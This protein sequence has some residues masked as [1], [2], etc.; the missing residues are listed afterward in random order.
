MARPTLLPD[1]LFFRIGEVSELV[2]VRP[3]VLR[4]WEEEFGILKPMKTR[5]AHRQYRRRD[6]ELA[7]VIKKL[8]HE[9]GFTV[10][11]AR[12]K[13]RE[14]GHLEA[15]AIGRQAAEA[16]TRALELRAELLAVRADLTSLLARIDAS[17][18]EESAVRERAKP[19]TSEVQASEVVVRIETS[20]RSER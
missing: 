10:A 9:D 19:S 18:R 4:Y 1:K 14:L 20:A 16:S 13:L 12:K 17:S 5:G 7:L 2:G 15:V 3:H 6:V 11:G 8:L